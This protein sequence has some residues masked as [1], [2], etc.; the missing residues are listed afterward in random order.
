[1]LRE[2]SGCVGKRQGKVNPFRKT[3]C[4]GCVAV[5]LTANVPSANVQLWLNEEDASF[6]LILDPSMSFNKC[7]IISL[8]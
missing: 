1:M 7:G 3:R 5:R 8:D 4:V 2:G 6:F